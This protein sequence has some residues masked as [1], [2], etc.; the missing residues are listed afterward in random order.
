MVAENQ[1]VQMSGTA[2]DGAVAA[3]S[4]TV[5]M[6]VLCGMSGTACIPVMVNSS[7]ALQTEVM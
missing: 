6:T 2:F 4:H 5:S 1:F 7:G 3:G